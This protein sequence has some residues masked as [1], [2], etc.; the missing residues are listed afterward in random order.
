MKSLRIANGA[1]FLGDWLAA[2]QQLVERAQID[3][4]SIEHLA[5]LTMSILARQREK[6]PAAGFATD[7]LEILRSLTPA[8][9]AQPQLKIIA[10]SGGMNPLSCAQAAAEILH[11]AQLDD[12]PLAAVTGDDLL[13]R[14]DELTR[15]GCDF[16]NLETGEPLSKLL[17]D[18][19]AI[20]NP[21]SAIVSANAYLGARPIAG[22]LASGARI[23]ITGRVADASL[24]VAPCLH[25]FGWAW[26]DWNRLAAASVAGHLIECGAQVTGGYST[27]W[28]TYGL[29]DVGYPIA[30]IDAAGS[31]LIS[32]PVGT[33][34]AV[35]RTTVSE[36]LVYEIGDPRHYLTPDVDCDFTTVE[37][38]EIGADRV[39]VRGASGRPATDSYKVSLAY[40]DGFMAS[41]MLLVYGSDCLEK[42]K[43]CGEIILARVKSAGFELARTNLELLGYKAGVPGAFFHR[44]YQPPGELV[45]RLTAHDPRRE[46]VECFARQ[47]APLITSG[48]AGLAG[49]ASGRPEVRPV[50]AYW[51]TLVLKRLVE[52]VVKVQPVKEWLLRYHSNPAASP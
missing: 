6:N 47:F 49:Y 14:L 19:S 33:G 16:A 37:V 48:P 20:R 8:L 13:P 15:Q 17:S 46:A 39:A 34:G 10:N 11:E 26:E 42:A 1:G 50:F 51:P 9:N 44:K 3:Y 2:P 4:L 25:E 35:N 38:E 22:A 7:F 27:G 29:A 43:A 23:V 21:Q 5:E 28:T 12:L 36:Q 45:L 40:R 18:Q 32:K 31:T 30:E 41:G 24:T 52:P